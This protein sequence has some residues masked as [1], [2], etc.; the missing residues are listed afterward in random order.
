MSQQAKKHNFSWGD[1]FAVIDH[2]TPTDPQ[3]CKTFTVTQGE[4]DTARQLRTAGTFVPTTGM[5]MTKYANMFP[6]CA[7]TKSTPTATVPPSKLVATAHAK[8]ESATKKSKIEKVPQKR[9]R[10][11]NKIVDALLAIPTKPVLVTAFMQQHGVSL[12]V[13][14]QSKRFISKLDVTTATKIGSVNVKQ[15][16]ATKSLMIWRG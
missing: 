16:K 12:A 5:N 8:P 4:L 9:G 13:L 3:I 2:F 1:R 14:R 7:A 11:G 10:K 6:T 15:D